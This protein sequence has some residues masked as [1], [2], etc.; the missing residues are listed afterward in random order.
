MGYNA[1]EWFIANYGKL[2]ILFHIIDSLWILII[3]GAIF[4]GGFCAGV[5]TTNSMSSCESIVSNCQAQIAIVDG[6]ENLDKFLQLKKKY[7]HLK[8]V[9]KIILKA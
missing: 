8:V 7:P 5:Y 2:M 9:H 3:L 4:A 6:K 1:P